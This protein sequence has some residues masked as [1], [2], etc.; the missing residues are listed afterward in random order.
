M[1][2]CLMMNKN[3]KLSDVLDKVLENKIKYSSK[4]RLAFK[5]YVNSSNET[6]SMSERSRID[7]KKLLE[8]KTTNNVNLFDMNTEI[9]N[10]PTFDLELTEIILDKVRI[11]RSEQNAKSLTMPGP[12]LETELKVYKSEEE[13]KKDYEYLYNRLSASSYDVISVRNFRSSMQLK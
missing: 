1:T 2:L 4:D 13:S 12:Y 8:Y 10:L 11:G 9:R 7:Y 3:T 5:T 6:R